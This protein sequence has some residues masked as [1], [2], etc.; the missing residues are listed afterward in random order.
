VKWVF[1]NGVAEIADGKF[2]DGV[3]GGRPI[4]YKVK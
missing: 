4:R 2:Q 1:V 3:L